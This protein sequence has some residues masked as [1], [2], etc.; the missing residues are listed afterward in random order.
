MF[1]MVVIVIFVHQIVSRL[2]A[3]VKQY[4]LRQLLLRILE[5]SGK[6]LLIPGFIIAFIMVFPQ[7]GSEGKRGLVIGIACL[8]SLY[9]LLREASGFRNDVVNALACLRVKIDNPAGNRIT[10]IEILVFN[11]LMFSKIS[12]SMGHYHQWK[13]NIE[14]EYKKQN[15]VEDRKGRERTLSERVN[16]LLHGEGSEYDGRMSSMGD[17][18]MKVLG[19][20]TMANMG[21]AVYVQGGDE[22]NAD[23]YAANSDIE[24]SVT[25]R[26]HG[27]TPESDD[28]EVDD[29]VVRG[30]SAAALNRVNNHQTSDDVVVNSLHI[31]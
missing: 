12:R 9:I 11:F 23:N 4:P 20:E 3:K 30:I 13:R 21:H 1:L 18:Q 16:K 8:V 5:I 17:F 25:R 7:I 27:R 28:E 19:R 6:T 2:S 29:E 10:S 24:T 26:F 14:K 31:I 15:G 22:S